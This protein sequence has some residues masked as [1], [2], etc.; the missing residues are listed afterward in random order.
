MP[1]RGVKISPKSRAHFITH[2][3]DF[4]ERMMVILMCSGMK[5]SHIKGVGCVVGEEMEPAMH[6]CGV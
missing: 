4:M 2:V 1:N 3:P 6:E 5:E